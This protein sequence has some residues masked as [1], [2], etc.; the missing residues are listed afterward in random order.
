MGHSV[1]TRDAKGN[2]RHLYSAHPRMGPE[3]QQRGIDLLSPIWHFMDLT[4]QGRGD[5][6]AS[7]EYGTRPIFA[8]SEV[9][10]G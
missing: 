2:V 1:F 5:W 8:G 9:A 10:Q 7:L 3:I 6:F 4:P